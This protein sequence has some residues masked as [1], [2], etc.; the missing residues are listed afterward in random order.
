L[1]PKQKPFP[2]VLRRATLFH[3][4]HGADIATPRVENNRPGS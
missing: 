2:A 1:G 3:V 4:G